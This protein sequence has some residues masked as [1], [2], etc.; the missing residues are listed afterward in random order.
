[1]LSPQPGITDITPIDYSPPPTG[2]GISPKSPHP[3]IRLDDQEVIV[4]LKPYTYTVDA[5]FHLFNTGETSTEWIGFPK[6]STGR[7]PGPLG[8]VDDFIRF[9][10]SVNGQTIA[11]TEERDLI[12]G[13]RA[14]Q[15]GILSRGKN[16]DGWLVGE[17]AFPGMRKRRFAS[18]TRHVTAIAEWV[19]AKLCTFTG[20]AGTGRTG[21]ER[22]SSSST[23]R[24]KAAWIERMQ[25][26]QGMRPRNTGSV[27]D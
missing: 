25:G 8:R 19:A 5:I 13:A 23:V 22:P 9:E 11:F 15:V 3:A 17:G 21:S 20:P 26:S 10:G 16:H 6:N 4:R 27:E 12:K 7:S 1:M 2:G 18:G 24:K 14:T